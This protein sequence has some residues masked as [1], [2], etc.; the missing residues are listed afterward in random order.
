MVPFRGQKAI[1]LPL[2]VFRLKRSTGAFAEP[3]RVL[4]RKNMTGDYV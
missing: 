1:L 3:L 2:R 4:N